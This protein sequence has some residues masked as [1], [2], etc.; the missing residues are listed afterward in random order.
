MRRGIQIS[1]IFG[2]IGFMFTFF[3]NYG[4]NLLGT[5]LIRG[6]LGFFIWFVLAFLLIWVLGFIIKQ[7]EV[8]EAAGAYT[9]SNE[10]LGSNVDIRT[11]DE[12]EELINLL[13]PKPAEESGKN[14]DFTPLTPPKLVSMK[15]PEELAKAVRH[16][17]EE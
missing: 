13:K 17:K 2:A 1:L 6:V 10:E 15:D 12:D 5:S 16:L 9:E 7:S 3:T 4:H 11:P 8:P 14:E